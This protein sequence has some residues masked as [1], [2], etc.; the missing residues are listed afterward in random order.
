MCSVQLIYPCSSVLTLVF[1]NMPS[2]L[3]CFGSA[4]DP[5]QL[6]SKAKKNKVEFLLTAGLT[7]NQWQNRR[8][9]EVYSLHLHP[10]C[11]HPIPMYPH[12][13]ISHT[14]ARARS[15]QVSVMTTI[16]WR[17]QRG[18]VIPSILSTF[19]T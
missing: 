14:H 3:F 11:R 5:W 6:Q 12:C 10:V 2:L 16:Q 9:S 7:P 4:P 1:I 15:V 19:Y 8:E 13:C 18:G 17:I